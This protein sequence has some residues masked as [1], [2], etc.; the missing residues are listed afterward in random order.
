MAVRIFAALLCGCAIAGSALADTIVVDL[1][2]NSATI[3]SNLIRNY[4]QVDMSTGGEQAAQVSL[5]ATNLVNHAG[6]ITQT[7]TGAMGVNV[8][9]TLDNSGGTLQTNA[10]NLT[11]AHGALN[12]Y[13]GNITINQ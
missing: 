2:I 1:N 13:N 9:G 11:I 4:A 10:T 5:S 8:S 12:H 7:G 6:T 3:A